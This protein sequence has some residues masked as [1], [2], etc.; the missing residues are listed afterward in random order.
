MKRRANFSSRQDMVK[1]TDG[2]VDL[3]LGPKG[4]DKNWVQTIPGQGWWAYL[5]FY[6]PAKSYF[7]KSWSMRDFE[8][9]DK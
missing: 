8:K 9:I 5:R 1:N 7:D 3:Y 6:T 2:S 4:K